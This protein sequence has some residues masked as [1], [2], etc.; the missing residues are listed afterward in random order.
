MTV[1]AKRALIDRVERDRGQDW[2]EGE[3]RVGRVSA[4]VWSWVFGTGED[5]D[6]RVDDD[7]V[8]PK[9]C[10]VS[11]HPGGVVV[12]EDLG[13]TNGTWVRPAASG[14]PGARVVG[15]V[16]IWPGWVVRIGRTD[17]PWEGR[18]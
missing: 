9:H 2:S 11:L 5:C 3:T 8:S 14:G 13:S 15:S 18:A 10:R 4:P 12:V 1:N 6:V 7:Y 17:I 16:R